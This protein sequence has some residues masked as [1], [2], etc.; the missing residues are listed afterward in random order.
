MLCV[1][2]L[3]SPSTR[4]SIIITDAARAT[5]QAGEHLPKDEFSAAEKARFLQI[6]RHFDVEIESDSVFAPLTIEGLFPPPSRDDLMNRSVD[7]LIEHERRVVLETLSVPKFSMGSAV[8]LN[9]PQAGASGAEAKYLETEGAHLHFRAQCGSPERGGGV[10]DVRWSSQIE[11]Q[12]GQTLQVAPKPPDERLQR[13]SSCQFVELIAS[14][15]VIRE[16]GG[17]SIGR[18]LAGGGSVGF[19]DEDGNFDAATPWEEKLASLF[20]TLEGSSYSDVVAF[21]EVLKA[22]DK[23]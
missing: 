11:Y 1:S 22:R 2:A 5:L 23:R 12:A 4:E 6:R 17:R 21:D 9:V 14:L 8:T 13:I 19:F 15:R 16:E 10:S 7:S 20:W 18:T 3:A